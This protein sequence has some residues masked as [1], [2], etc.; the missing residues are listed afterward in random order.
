M[1]WE[2]LKRLILTLSIVLSTSLF[3]PER[4]KADDSYIYQD[5]QTS[6]SGNSKCISERNITASSYP[7]KSSSITTSAYCTLFF[8][9]TSGYPKTVITNGLPTVIYGQWNKIWE[10]RIQATRQ[11][12][13]DLNY[14][15]KTPPATTLLSPTTYKYRFALCED[16]NAQTSRQLTSPSSQS[17]RT[18]Q[19]TSVGATISR[20]PQQTTNPTPQQ[21]S[22][23]APQQSSVPAPQQ[24]SDPAPQQTTNPTPEIVIQNRVI[25][26][27]WGVPMELVNTSVKGKM[28]TTPSGESRLALYELQELK[29]YNEKQFR[30]LRISLNSKS[31][32]SKQTECGNYEILGN[33]F[34]DRLVNEDCWN[35]QPI[36]LSEIDGWVYE[37]TLYI[38]APVT[39][40]GTTKIQV[41]FA[42][43]GSKKQKIIVSKNYKIVS[44]DIGASFFERLE[45]PEYVG[46]SGNLKGIIRLKISN[47]LIKGKKSITKRL[48]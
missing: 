16:P 4:A 34:G 33:V 45:L 37:R 35:Y 11:N 44:S 10:G 19:V 13:L 42:K 21:S 1:C 5:L 18:Y 48:N 26:S 20:T 7:I 41:T 22:D 15:I 2:M 23:P 30:S 47:D 14:I 31:K 3:L 9:Q 12:N 38:Q 8:Y 27:E 32:K 17:C 25:Q 46:E 29:D 43:Y 39:I 36:N 28:I 40:S 24:T 6:Y